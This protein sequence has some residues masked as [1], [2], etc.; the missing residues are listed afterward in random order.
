M[1]PALL[2]TGCDTPSFGTKLTPRQA[3]LIGERAAQQL[4]A[5]YHPATTDEPGVSTFTKVAPI[6]AA[7]KLKM[8][9]GADCVFEAVDSDDQFA[10]SLP[11]G[12]VFVSSGLL[13][14]IGNDSDEMASVL[15]HEAGHVALGH[16]AQQLQAALGD[17]TV[18]DMVSEG[19][20]EELT[21]IDLQLGRLSYTRD[22][23]FDADKFAVRLTSIAGYDPSA[24]V[25]FL[26]MIESVPHAQD[27]VSWSDSHPLPKSRIPR[28]DDDIRALNRSGQKLK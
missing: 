1:A 28:L 5:Q 17:T 10:T 11:D 9:G 22:E 13:A 15:A 25:R 14:L 19:K 6:V 8:V 7:E 24:M 4:Q 21:N 2:L 12:H 27:Q 23:E 3:Q 16:D 26:Q 20:Y 18:T